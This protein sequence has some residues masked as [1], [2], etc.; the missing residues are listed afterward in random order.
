MT[1]VLPSVAVAYETLFK[2]FRTYHHASR[3]L[4]T[5]GLLLKGLVEDDVHEY[6]QARISPVWNLRAAHE[7]LH[8]ATILIS[9]FPRPAYSLLDSIARY[10][11]G[12]ETYIVA[13]EDA[14]NFAVAVQLA[15]DPLL[16]VL[17]H[18]SEQTGAKD[19]DKGPTLTFFNSG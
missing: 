12:I 7:L 10:S 17:G 15:E 6:L 8:R 2:E 5:T 3:D 16:H 18:V 11:K 4:L 14:N 1:C 9:E 13:A 19:A